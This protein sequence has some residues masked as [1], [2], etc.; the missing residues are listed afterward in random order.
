MD[1]WA[2]TRNNIAPLTLRTLSLFQDLVQDFTRQGYTFVDKVQDN[3]RRAAVIAQSLN[4]DPNAKNTPKDKFQMAVYEKLLNSDY[5][6]E[7]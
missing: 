1:P 6:N 5:L 2:N 3:K 4:D 7:L